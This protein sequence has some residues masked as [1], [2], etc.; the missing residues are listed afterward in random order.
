MTNFPFPGLNLAIATPFDAEGRIDYA[1]LEQN[2]ERYL[3]LGVPG[4]VLSSGTGM[5]VYLTRVES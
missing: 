3:A 4:F 1:K 5:H 2:I